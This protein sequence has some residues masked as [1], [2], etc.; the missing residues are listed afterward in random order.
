MSVSALMS[1]GVKS[2]AASYAQL[3]ATGHNIANATVAGYSR[4]EARLATSPGQY[5]GSGFFGRG[6]D[7]TTVT[8]A[9]D[10]FLTSEAISTK[11]AAS[12]DS[13][14]LAQLQ[15][16][17]KVFQTGQGSIGD[18]V[19]QL[20]SAVSDLTS[21][22]SDLSARQVVLARAKDLAASFKTAAMAM[23]SVQAGVTDALTSAVADVNSLAQGI[24]GLNKQIASVQGLGQ[25]PNDLLDQRE[26]LISDLSAQIQV[27]RVDASDGTA[28]LFI[29]GGQTLVLG[30]E[31]TPL[32]VMQDAADPTRSAVGVVSGGVARAL[33]PDALGGGAIK[34][35]LDFQNVDL[36][37]GRGFV[38]TLQSE[39]YTAFNAQQTAGYDLNGNAGQ[40][41]FDATQADGMALD[42]SGAAL[43][44]QAIAASDS[45]SVSNNGNALALLALQDAKLASGNTATF[46]NSWV[47]RVSDIAVRVQSA[48]TTSEMSASVAAQAEQARSAQS[49]VNLDEEAARLIQYQQS[50]QAAAKVLQVAQTLFDTL[51]QAAAA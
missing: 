9:H 31:A 28:S 34:G 29:G 7:V 13:A 40:A 23:D 44:P 3:Q 32:Q 4:Q 24:A 5:T 21:N 48:K 51:L 25:T 8:R 16:L 22:P 26:A 18:A 30:G 10:N 19:S 1:L 11:S 36:V 41:L 14:H 50:Y 39:V 2:M 15:S 27:T 46:T 37:D 38:A 43:G 12:M 33:D 49:G 45:A 35:L 6:V 42:S 17:E 47:Q 20:F